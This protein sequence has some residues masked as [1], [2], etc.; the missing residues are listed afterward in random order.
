MQAKLEE[1][2]QSLRTTNASLSEL[3]SR[4]QQAIQDQNRLLKEC[5]VIKYDEYRKD[6]LLAST[7]T[8][9]KTLRSVADQMKESL[10]EAGKEQQRLRDECEQARKEV[11]EARNTLQQKEKVHRSLQEETN[12][13]LES[14]HTD[15]E[16]MAEELKQRGLRAVDLY[17]R[18]VKTEEECARL[19]R[20]KTYAEE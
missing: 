5:V 16:H 7:Q 9:L 18:V 17:A 8:Q 12:L 3:K 13:V 19:E 11:E 1:S 15:P 20:A 2:T 14:L 10:E 4:S 6:E